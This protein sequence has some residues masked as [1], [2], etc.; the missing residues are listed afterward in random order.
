MNTEEHIITEN[1]I[2]KSSESSMIPP[3]YA[4]LM[5]PDKCKWNLYL[6]AKYAMK[7]AFQM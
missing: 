3:K 7:M 4:S 2:F 5:L 6:N 1:S